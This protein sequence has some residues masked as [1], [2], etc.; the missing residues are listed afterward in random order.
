MTYQDFLEALRTLGYKIPEVPVAS[1][2]KKSYGYDQT[3]YTSDG[4]VLYSEFH[5]CDDDKKR[6]ALIH[7]WHVG[8]VSGGSCWD[9]G[10]SRHNAYVT[11]DPEPEWTDLVAILEHFC[12]NI[13]YLQYRSLATKFKTDSYDRN[14]YYGNS[15]KYSIRYVYLEDLYEH[16]NEKGLLP[17]A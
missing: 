9:E 15:S 2:K 4:I 10:E 1:K 3:D 12:P 5:Y 6:L 11:G 17:D 16:L 8:G 13:T 14:E 7:S